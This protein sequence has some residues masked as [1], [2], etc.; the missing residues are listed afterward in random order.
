VSISLDFLNFPINVTT[1]EKI[2]KLPYALGTSRDVGFQTTCIKLYTTYLQSISLETGRKLLAKATIIMDSLSAV[3]DILGDVESWPTCIILDI[4]VFKCNTPNVQNVAAFMYGNGVP[5]ENAVD[6]FV[7]CIGKD[8]YVSCAMKNWYAVWDK[9]LYADHFEKELFREFQT[10]D[11]VNGKTLSQHE[12][13]W[14]KVD[15]TR[16]GTED[17]GYP[18]II[19]T[20]IAHVRSSIS[21]V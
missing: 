21:V 7:V 11:V 18:L 12:G 6:C 19:T 1:F 3:K 8:Y 13:V 14:P 5:V 16:I 10:L 20:T 15:F 4:F 2:S 9:H 17:T